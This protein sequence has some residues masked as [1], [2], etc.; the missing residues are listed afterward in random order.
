MDMVPNLTQNSLL[1]ASKFA[2]EKY[3][4]VLTPEEVLMFDD[5]GDLQHTIY[6]EAIL[7]GWRCKTSGLWRL[8]LKTMVMNQNE[9][10][11]LLD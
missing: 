1:S 9:D 7:I 8:P 5:L 6:K 11:I 10:T 2:D 3:V 4:T